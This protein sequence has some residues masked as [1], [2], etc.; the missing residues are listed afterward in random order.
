MGDE[1]EIVGLSEEKKKDSSN[2]NRNVQ[3]VTR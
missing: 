1:V 3:K 2:R